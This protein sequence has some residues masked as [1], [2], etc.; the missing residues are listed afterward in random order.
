MAGMPKVWRVIY[1]NRQA[2][3]CT[4][5]VTAFSPDGA[6]GQVFDAEKV[7][8]IEERPDITIEAKP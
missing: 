1:L 6:V 7:L 5:F 4:K 8:R 2:L 3:R